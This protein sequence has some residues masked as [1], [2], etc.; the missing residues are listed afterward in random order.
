M[1]KNL[2]ICLFY[3]ILIL[4]LLTYFSTSTFVLPKDYIPPGIYI[5]NFKKNNNKNNF[6]KIFIKNNFFFKVLKIQLDI[7][8]EFINLI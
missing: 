2:K 4:I 8:Q 1:E 5:Y 3:Q 6:K 7:T